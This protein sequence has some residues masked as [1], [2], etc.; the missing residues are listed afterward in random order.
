VYNGMVSHVTN[1]VWLFELGW[2]LRPKTAPVARQ[3]S[4]II[5]VLRVPH[6]DLPA[7]RGIA[8]GGEEFTGKTRFSYQAVEW[9]FSIVKVKHGVAESGSFKLNCGEPRPQKHRCG[10]V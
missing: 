1:Q 4:S 5:I 10:L 7:L 3:I 6:E 2:F 8:I 9:A